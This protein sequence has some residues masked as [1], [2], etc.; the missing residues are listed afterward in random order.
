MICIVEFVTNMNFIKYLE[1]PTKV[2]RITLRMLFGFLIT[3]RYRETRVKFVIRF[4]RGKR[5]CA[6]LRLT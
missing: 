2:E 5:Q 3:E 6:S 4:T 1:F